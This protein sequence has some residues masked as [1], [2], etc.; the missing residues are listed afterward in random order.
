MENRCIG[1]GA[2]IP[3]NKRRCPACEEG[4]FNMA[5]NAWRAA[6]KQGKSLMEPDI[7]IATQN[8]IEAKYGL[9]GQTTPA[10]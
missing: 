5:C 4:A 8:T 2:P 10:V 3:E 6:R 9:L 1:C 7:F